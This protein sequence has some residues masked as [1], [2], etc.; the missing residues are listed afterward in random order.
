[1]L[2]RERQCVAN[3]RKIA[4][5]GLEVNEL[6]GNRQAAIAR[7]TKTLL[8]AYERSGEMKVLLL[9][10]SPAGPFPDDAACNRQEKLPIVYGT[11]Y[12]GDRLNDVQRFWNIRAEAARLAE[13]AVP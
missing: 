3:E 9:Q 10:A 13:M 7:M 1:M 2:R 5:L 11:P 8:E 6:S 12:V 4:M